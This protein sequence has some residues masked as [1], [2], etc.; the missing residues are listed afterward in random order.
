MY[1]GVLRDEER[2][3]EKRRARET[4]LEHSRVRESALRARQGF[5]SQQRLV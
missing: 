1:A 2:Q 5:E 3:E 4:D